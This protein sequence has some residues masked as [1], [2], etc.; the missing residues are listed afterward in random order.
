MA[1][2]KAHIAALMTSP[3]DIEAQFYEA[4]QHGDLEKLMAHRAATGSILGF[5]GA[6]DLKDRMAALELPCD[7]LVPAALENQITEENCDRIQAKIVAEGANG[8][9]T[10]AAGDKLYARGVM[11]IPD[12][13]AN[14]GGVTV[15]YFE[16]LKNLSH[17]RFGRLSKRHEEANERQMLK[18]IELATG[19]S[20]S[21]AQRSA[22]AKG[23]DE[24]DLVNSGL[25]ETMINAY[26]GLRD[27]RKQHP[28]VPDLRTAAFLTAIHKVARSYMTLGIFP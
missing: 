5:P 3:E 13:Y 11:V 2:P 17:V 26:N 8:P 9:T 6:T 21:E 28:E 22:L 16:W 15:S 1:R 23:P 12:I 14:A 7:I 10:A 24:L 27:T 25:E 4:L 19:T 18:A 20:F